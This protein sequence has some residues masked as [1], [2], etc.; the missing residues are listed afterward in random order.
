MKSVIEAFVKAT[1]LKEIAE[2]EK[3][4]KKQA[5]RR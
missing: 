1:S 4:E 5:E 3:K 2:K